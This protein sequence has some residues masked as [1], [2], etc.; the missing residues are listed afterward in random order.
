MPFLAHYC[1]VATFG[2]V[3]LT[4]GY[5]FEPGRNLTVVNKID[6]LKVT[7]ALGAM[8]YE[9]NA[10][11]WEYVRPQTWVAA[12]IGSFLLNIL[13]FAGV[14]FFLRKSHLSAAAIINRKRS[15]STQ[16]LSGL[17]RSLNSSLAGGGRGGGVGPGGV[18]R[19]QYYQAI[20]ITTAA[21]A[22]GGGN[23][24]QQV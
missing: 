18:P 16:S 6:E 14:I 13:L 8:L 22:A 2:Y 1:F 12:F 5:G 4:E 10:L 3:L 15:M 21:G 17:D 9:I 23:G 7:W 11:P 24:G 19:R 20:P